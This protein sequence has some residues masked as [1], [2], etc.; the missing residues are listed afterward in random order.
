MENLLQ[1]RQDVLM[2]P[3]QKQLWWQPVNANSTV[4]GETKTH[5][6]HTRGPVREGCSWLDCIDG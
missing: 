4:V 5:P 2:G 1:V 3:N 6:T